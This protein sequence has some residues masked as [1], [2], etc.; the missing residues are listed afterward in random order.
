MHSRARRIEAGAWTVTDHREGRTLPLLTAVCDLS[1]QAQTRVATE[2][3]ATIAERES[4][5]SRLRTKLDNATE[6]TS[7]ASDTAARAGL[8]EERAAVIDVHAL[9][10]E[11]RVSG[12]ERRTSDALAAKGAAD[13]EARAA[14][15]SGFDWPWRRRGALQDADEIIR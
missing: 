9:D 6:R 13:A 8:A 15:T 7:A 11:E 3:H 4:E 5:L 14:D 2:L 1:Y 12:A 10:A